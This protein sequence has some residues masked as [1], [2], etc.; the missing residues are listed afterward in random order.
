MIERW[1]T[2]K[3]QGICEACPQREIC[4][5]LKPDA[6]AFWSE[7][8]PACPLEKLPNVFEERYSKSH[9]ASAEPV[10]G[11]CDAPGG[12]TRLTRKRI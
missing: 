12:F 6:F 3:R 7:E 8:R 1:I 4:P 5:A 10:S 9:P 11:C 2:T